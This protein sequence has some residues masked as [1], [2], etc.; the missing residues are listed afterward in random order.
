MSEYFIMFNMDNGEFLNP[1]SI[2]EPGNFESVITGIT[3]QLLAYLLITKESEESR[4]KGRPN[5]YRGRWQGSRIEILGDEADE[6]FYHTFSMEGK[7][8]TKEVLKDY[9]ASAIIR[10]TDNNTLKGIKLKT[11]Q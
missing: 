10:K 11:K 9:N 3:S 2:D 6:Q 1:F 8:I 4:F 7:D 5:K